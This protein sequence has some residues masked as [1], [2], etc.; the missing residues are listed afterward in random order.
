MRKL[1]INVLVA[2]FSPGGVN[3]WKKI[4]SEVL[5]AN[6]PF[7][8]ANRVTDIDKSIKEKPP[9]VLILDLTLP[10]VDGLKIFLD[11]CNMA[12]TVPVVVVLASD[13]QKLATLVIQKGAQDC[14]VKKHIDAFLLSR[15]LRCAIGRQAHLME[16]RSFSFI[17]ELT[18][19][20]NRRGFLNF[21]EQQFKIA[22]RMKQS[23]L[24]VFADLDGL[25]S[26]NDSFGHHR[27]DLALM[28]T[29]HVLREA[30]RETDIVARL[31]GDEFAA[32]LISGKESGAQVILKHFQETLDEHNG[33]RN[34]NFKLSVSLGVALYDPL[35][36]CSIVVLLEKAD[37][38]M[39]E[40]KNAKKAK[41]E[42][43]PVTLKDERK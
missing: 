23:L 16:L 10:D 15:S 24:L 17:D 25:K 30:F 39:Y 11:V 19:L 20:Y 38:L 8:R 14:L 2:E 42:N 22:D 27:G 4:L 3:Y 26:I 41:S 36:P 6:H 13:D 5:D 33:Y 34:R 28:E 7:T 21:A 9:D 18:G 1:K 12:P 32:L 31:G 35:A 29:A 43:Q 37:Q 40:Q